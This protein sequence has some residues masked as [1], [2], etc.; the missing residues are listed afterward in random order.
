MECFA[1]ELNIV[2]IENILTISTDLTTDGERVFV[3]DLCL[4]S[5][6]SQLL[7]QFIFMNAV[8]IM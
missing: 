2:N 6:F 7:V 1:T 3:I 5:E 4:L 8:E